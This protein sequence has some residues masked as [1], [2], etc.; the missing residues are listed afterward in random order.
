MAAKT[1]KTA[2]TNPEKTP[3]NTNTEQASASEENQTAAQPEKQSQLATILVGLLIIASGLLI[4][5]Y[6]QRASLTETTNQAE[7]QE[8]TN[9]DKS[10]QD[11]KKA[12]SKESDQSDESSKEGQ[13]TVVAGDSLW[14]IAEKAYGDGHQWKK[15]ADANTIQN[16]AY[17]Q[18]TVE[19]GQVLN[20][21][22]SAAMAQSPQV[23]DEDK[24]VAGVQEI[25]ETPSTAISTYTVQPGDTLWSIA[26]TAYGDGHAWNSI[27]SDPHNQLSTMSNGQPLLHTGNILYLPDLN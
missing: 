16:N 17:G 25:N 7:Q 23:A 2:D 22:D 12:D 3:V 4:Y 9:K 8:Q 15:I 10:G 20:V 5:N 26:E 11:G 27:F 1:K 13:Y 14:S 19:I 6:F 21:P 18:P 24:T